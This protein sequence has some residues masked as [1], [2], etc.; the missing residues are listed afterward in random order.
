V[1]PTEL[2]TILAAAIVI[3]GLAWYL[4]GRRSDMAARRADPDL[5]HER[6]QA[7]LAAEEAQTDAIVR[8]YCPSC[9]ADRDFRDRVCLECGYRLP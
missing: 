7:Y 6:E 2:L 4:R 8:R 9:Q 3:V 1:T 5:P